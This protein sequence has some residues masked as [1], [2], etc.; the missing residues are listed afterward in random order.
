MAARLAGAP[1]LDPT[2][3]E[4]CSSASYSTRVANPFVYVAVILDAWSRMI[5]CYATIDVRLTL[6]ALR[7]AVERRTCRQAADPP[8]TPRSS[9]GRP[10]APAV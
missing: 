3:E 10:W 8:N 7:A 1:V 6:A 4:K 2:G 5:V 9:I